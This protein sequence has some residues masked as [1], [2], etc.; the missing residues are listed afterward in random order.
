[1]STPSIDGTPSPFGDPSRPDPAFDLTTS[2]DKGR[3]L[4]IQRP[5]TTDVQEIMEL[6]N[7]FASANLMLHRGPQ[8]VYENI[9][10]FL[11]AVDPGVTVGTENGRA[12]H[13]VAA[14]ASLHVLWADTAEVRSVAVH[15]SYQHQG[16]GRL[17]VERLKREARDLGVHRLFTFT[18][19]EPFFQE[20]GFSRIDRRD[21]PHKMWNEC[22]RCPKFFTCDEIGMVLNIG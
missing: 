17:L 9:R 2:A 5:R 19:N 14:C 1:M 4:A 21:V 12:L 15:G 18:L 11:V 13:R 3:V 6:I 22:S 10:D 20:L 8:Y 16:Y 7:G